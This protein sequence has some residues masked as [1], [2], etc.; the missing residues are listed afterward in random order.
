MK[1]LVLGL[2]RAYKATVSPYM[3]G[4]CRFSP[5]CSEYAAEAVQAYGVVKGSAMTARRLVR[6][7][8]GVEGGY[9]PAVPD[10]EFESVPVLTD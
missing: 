9:D 5:T 4:Q 2:I 6:C 3:P 10:A 1:P 8:P 7:R